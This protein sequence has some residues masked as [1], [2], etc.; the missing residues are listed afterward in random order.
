M[1][2]LLHPTLSVDC[3]DGRRMK[4]PL[5]RRGGMGGARSD[6]PDA[7]QPL[8]RFVHESLHMF[9]SSIQ[10]QINRATYSS[11]RLTN[12]YSLEQ[13]PCPYVCFISTPKDALHKEASRLVN[14]RD[15]LQ[16]KLINLPSVSK[17]VAKSLRRRLRGKEANEVERSPGPRSTSEEGSKMEDWPRTK[18]LSNT[19]RPSWGPDDEVYFKV[20]THRED[21][22]PIDLSG[23]MLHITLMDGRGGGTGK[24]LGSFT[25][26][27]AKIIQSSRDPSSNGMQSHNSRAT[28]AALWLSNNETEPFGSPQTKKGA[29]GLKDNAARKAAQA[30]LKKARR[31]AEE[32][33]E[34]GEVPVERDRPRSTMFF[35][36]EKKAP[37]PSTKSKKGALPPPPFAGIVSNKISQFFS[38]EKKDHDVGNSFDTTDPIEDPNVPR[39]GSPMDTNERRISS[40]FMTSGPS[41]RLREAMHTNILASKAVKDVKRTL[42]RQSLA[43][44]EQIDYSVPL[45]PTKPFSE[46]RISASRSVD[47]HMEERVPVST[48]RILQY[49]STAANE[50]D[51]ASG[52]R[53]PPK[54]SPHHKKHLWRPHFHHREGSSALSHTPDDPLDSL[55]IISL[56]LDEPLTRNGK[57]VGRITCSLDAWWM[58]DDYAIDAPQRS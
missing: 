48:G 13:V 35:T 47:S 3:S 20:R 50:A 31:Q 36:P 34:L 7:L 53:S 16:V 14:L 5:F 12:D 30:S 43:H 41:D 58:E 17:T 32:S 51:N 55:K 15:Q 21:G 28:S 52:N 4:R 2:F 29:R 24:V 40:S 25:L 37:N 33:G 54:P 1:Y 10:C 23:S 8:Q 38:F 11:K 56:K 6:A 27:L 22:M 42:R 19:F 26:N 49:S 46:P 39:I 45:S 18:K 57:Q 9:V 44:S